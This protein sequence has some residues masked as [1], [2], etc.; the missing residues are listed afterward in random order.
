MTNVKFYFL[1]LCSIN[2]QT[3]VRHARYPHNSKCQLTELYPTLKKSNTLKIF[4]FKTRGHI[5]HPLCFH[6]MADLK[7]IMRSKR[8]LSRSQWEIDKRPVDLLLIEIDRQFDRIANETVIVGFFSRVNG[9][10]IG[11]A[12]NSVAI[13]SIGSPIDLSIASIQKITLY[14]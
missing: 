8:S 10:V 1:G 5:L 7:S 4:S 13:L 12:F 14:R 11:F 2:N 9:Y 3:N 6:L